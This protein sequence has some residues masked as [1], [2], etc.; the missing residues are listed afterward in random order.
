MKRLFLFPIFG[1]LFAIGTQAQQFAAVP[2]IAPVPVEP[3]YVVCGTGF[4]NGDCQLA[5][6]FM[7][8]ALNDLKVNI[9]AWRWVVVP[10]SQWKRT[11]LSFG[12]KP[13]VPAFS[14]PSVGATYVLADLVF[15]SQ[16]PDENLLYYTA[17]TGANRL[18]WVLAHET[19][20]IVCHTSDESKAE[21]A[22]KRIESGNRNVCR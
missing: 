10:A 9:P 5:T 11:A 3:A 12:V 13:S 6:G 15:P 22:A 8:V 20:H 4:G 14:S 16:R 19:G 7:R 17:R 18:R 21:G 1:F 2:D